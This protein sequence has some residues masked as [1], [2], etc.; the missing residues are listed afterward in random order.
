[1]IGT[2]RYGAM[3]RLA[4]AVV[5]VAG[6]RKDRGE[7][8][9]G[10]AAA[11]VAAVSDAGVKK[12]AEAG[13]V[14]EAAA[15]GRTPLA[16]AGPVEEGAAARARTRD[17]NA[18]AWSNMARRPMDAQRAKWLDRAFATLEGGETEYEFVGRKPAHMDAGRVVCWKERGLRGK[19]SVE[20]TDR[21]PVEILQCSFGGETQPVAV[22][23]EAADV[24][25]GA[26]PPGSCYAACGAGCKG[27]C[28]E[29]AVGCAPPPAGRTTS[30]AFACITLVEPPNKVPKFPWFKTAEGPRCVDPKRHADRTAEACTA[31]VNHF[32]PDGLVATSGK[33]KVCSAAECCGHHDECTGA[34]TNPVSMDFIKCHLYGERECGGTWAAAGRPDDTDWTIRLYNTKGQPVTGREIWDGTPI[35]VGECGWSNGKPTWKPPVAQM[36]SYTCAVDGIEH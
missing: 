6:C 5:A 22:L 27:I 18:D 16:E 35:Q 24:K 33:V 9:K 25:N 8:S 2:A 36:E 23:G 14:G 13:P 31:T 21:E 1:M 11:P 26:K 7:E 32:A 28:Q 4:L 12:A 3:G 30:P 10:E 17:C 34:H 15:G 20:P 29:V 19:W